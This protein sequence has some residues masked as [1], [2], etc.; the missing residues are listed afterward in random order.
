[1]IKFIKSDESKIIIEKYP[2]ANQINKKISDFVKSFGDRQFKLTNVKANMTDW[3]I[4]SPEISILKRW[5]MNV[6]SSE[7]NL[8]TERYDFF[9]ADFWGNHYQ[10]GDFTIFHDHVPATHSFCY[11]VKCSKNS[12]PFIFK[13]SN[14]K[15]NAEEGKLVIFPSYL[16]HYVPKEKDGDRVTLSGNIFPQIKLS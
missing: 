10:K 13:H 3:N 16:K 8:M 11:F 9:I 15:V 7:F 14:F 1:M 6:F 4:D 2:Y 12:S 5:I